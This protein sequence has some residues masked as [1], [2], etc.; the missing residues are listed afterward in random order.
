MVYCYCS[1]QRKIER[2][3]W[4]CNQE[5]KKISQSK[6]PCSL[7]HSLQVFR[8]SDALYLTQTWLVFTCAKL[9][10][11]WVMQKHLP[12]PA[13][14]WNKAGWG[15]FPLLGF[16]CQQC[17]LT[18]LQAAPHPQGRTQPQSIPPQSISD[19]TTKAL[20][21]PGGL[22]SSAGE[23]VGSVMCAH[24]C[25]WAWGC[26]CM[27][28]THAAALLSSLGACHHMI[29]LH[30]TSFI[31]SSFPTMPGVSL[32]AFH[33]HNEVCLLFFASFLG[34]DFLCDLP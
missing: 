25:E 32:S 21:G 24:P 5:V 19:C 29:P 12:K 3:R 6:Y 26:N 28:L 4:F 27:A 1:S 14:G 17:V 16:W 7:K 30:S 23:D 10:G 2:E 15:W 22:I 11:L 34:S 18:N 8:G 31:P 9:S 33:H 13:T 20:G